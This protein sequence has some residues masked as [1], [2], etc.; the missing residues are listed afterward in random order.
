MVVLRRLF[1]LSALNNF[2][3]TAGHI[4]G[5][6]NTVSDSLSRLHDPAHAIQTCANF[7]HDCYITAGKCYLNMR[8]HTPLAPFCTCR[9]GTNRPDTAPCRGRSLQ[10]LRLCRIN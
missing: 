3:I 1:W 6:A 4:P 5:K 10:V 2:Y 7:P 9:G 8:G